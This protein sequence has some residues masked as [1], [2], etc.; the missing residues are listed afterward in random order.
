[1]FDLVFIELSVSI[2]YSF[3]AEIANAIS[4]VQSRKMFIFIKT[5]HPANRIICS[6]FIVQH[7]SDIY[8]VY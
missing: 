3:V 1:M 6:V 8:T 2:S 4:N 5:R 7:R